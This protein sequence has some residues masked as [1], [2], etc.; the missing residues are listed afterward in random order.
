M[1]RLTGVYNIRDANITFSPVLHLNVLVWF[2]LKNFCFCEKCENAI[3]SDL[4]GCLAVQPY[5]KSYS[6]YFFI[7]FLCT[8]NAIT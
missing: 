8:V 1:L 7:I 6:F 2:V 5:L 3:I 4:L